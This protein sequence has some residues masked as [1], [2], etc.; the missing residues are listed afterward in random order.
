MPRDW[1]I[2]ANCKRWV[3][4]RGSLRWR[5]CWWQYGGERL[6]RW[7]LPHGMELT[8]SFSVILFRCCVAV[9][10]LRLFIDADL[11]LHQ[12][13]FLPTWLSIDCASCTRC[14]RSRMVALD[15]PH[16]RFACLWLIWQISS[17]AHVNSIW[18]AHGACL[19][20]RRLFRSS[21]DYARLRVAYRRPPR[22]LTHGTIRPRAHRLY[23]SSRTCA[24]SIAR[25]L[26]LL[27]L[28]SLH[29]YVHSARLAY[30]R[31]APGREMA[32]GNNRKAPQPAE[33]TEFPA[34]DL[35]SLAR[36]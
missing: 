36:R 12:Q 22:S 18:L 1:W 14:L 33:G 20:R 28:D 19:S 7:L 25:P 5:R 16:F 9:D 11:A 35:A 6:R 8:D 31:L 30:A 32:T 15:L 2:W 3:R 17:S 29:S 21:L 23:Y 26:W 27:L 10:L 24:R 34:V 13:Q 4:G